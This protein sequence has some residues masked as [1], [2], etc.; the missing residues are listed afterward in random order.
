MVI[1]AG[2]QG[3]RLRPHTNQCPKPLLTVNGAPILEHT[4]RRA[5]SCG[6]GR[7]V[8]S[9]GY[10]GHMIEEHFGE[11]ASWNVEIQYVQE[12]IPLG[13]AGALSLLDPKPTEPFIVTN[14]DILTGIDY[15]DLIEQHYATE[16]EG[17]MA[18]RQYE[19]QNPFGVVELDGADI[20][21]LV[22]KPVTRCWVNAGIYALSPVALELLPQGWPKDMPGLFDLL[23]IGHRT[24]AYQMNE[25][26]ADLGT[27]AD[28][29]M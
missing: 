24:M 12:Q 13:T 14:G 22:E 18:V 21:G 6:F 1:M 5:K 4:I 7:F 17:T 15:G 26:W 8:I 16:A 11:G 19:H 20:I 27:P 3:T 9:L 23:R 25:S 2:G 10:L 28:I 29:G